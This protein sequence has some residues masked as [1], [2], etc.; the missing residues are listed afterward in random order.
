[1]CGSHARYHTAVIAEWC[2][3]TAVSEPNHCKLPVGLPN[4]GDLAR[5]AIDMLIQCIRW[6]SNRTGRPEAARTKVLVA[7]SEVFEAAVDRFS[8]VSWVRAPDGPPAIIQKAIARWF[9]CCW[10]LI[11][12]QVRLWVNYFINA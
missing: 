3:G 6:R 8:S 5:Q 1:M 4:N 9:F 11:S 2:E 12:M 7:S 10:N